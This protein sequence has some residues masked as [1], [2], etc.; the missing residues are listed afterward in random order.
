VLSVWEAL[1]LNA[2]VTARVFRH[3]TAS[4]AEVLAGTA[5]DGVELTAMVESITHTSSELSIRLR[6]HMELYA[7]GQQ[8]CVREVLE[9]RMNDRPL[10]IA[11]TDTINDYGE[12]RGERRMTVVARSRDSSPLWRQSKIATSSYSMTTDLSSIAREIL[13]FLHMTDAEIDMPSSL[14]VF[15]VHTSTQMADMTA[16]EMLTTLMQPSGIEPYVDALGRF[17]TVSRGFSRSATHILSADRIISIGGVRSIA[18]TTKVRVKWLDPNLSKTFNT[19]QKLADATITAGFFQATQEKDV[20][21]SD[22]QLQRADDCRL[23]IK[24]SCNS[25]PMDVASEEFTMVSQ[26]QGRITLTTVPWVS[27]AALGAMYVMAR[28]GDVGDIAPPFG[29]I[30]VTVGR[31]L[32]AIAEVAL[33][34]IIMSIGTGVYEIWGTPFDY[35]HATN[36][37]IAYSETAPDWAESI[38]EISNDFV[39]N[40]EMAQGLAVRELVYACL[41]ANSYT[42][43]LVDDPS[44]ERGDILEMPDSSRF[45]VTDYSRETGRGK[46]HTFSVTGFRI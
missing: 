42:M 15:T 37:T 5:T 14:G 21:F 7:A 16:W 18:P 31:R 41:A 10:C 39:M 36:T 20:Y 33:M 13:G 6:W 19:E 4:P 24:Q 46:P 22:D 44:I 29:G 1:P 8:P 28:T 17:K 25:G 23:V 11:I 27:L 38:M 34:L 40:E 9:V 43:A 12:S 30:T 3:P 32:H 45:Y 2:T 35:V 26:T